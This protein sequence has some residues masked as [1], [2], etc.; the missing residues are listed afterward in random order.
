M[1]F[2]QTI[3]TLTR[4]SKEIVIY[5][6]MLGLSATCSRILSIFVAAKYDISCGLWDLVPQLGLEPR[7]SQ[8]EPRVDHQGSL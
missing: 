7:P 8:W 1:N 5:L 4:L 6:A 3:N 2:R